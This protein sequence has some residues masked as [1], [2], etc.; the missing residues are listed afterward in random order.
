MLVDV[1]MNCIDD[2]FNFQ[3]L[4]FQDVLDHAVARV[5]HIAA[6]YGMQHCNRCGQFSSLV[7]ALNGIAGD[8]I[9][10]LWRLAVD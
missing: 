10:D 5:E 7:C 3:P 4:L 6:V 2:L 9:T 1:V 8:L